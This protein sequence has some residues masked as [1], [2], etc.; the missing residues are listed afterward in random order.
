VPTYVALLRSVN[1]GGRKLPMERLRALFAD[2]GHTNVRTYIQSGNVVFGASARRPATVRSAIEAAIP[3]ELGLDVAVLVRTPAE[4]A[5]VVAANPFG[6]DA[7]VTFLDALPD[8]A[9]VAALD[10]R[11]YAPDGFHVAGR[12]VYV[13]CANGYGRTKI[14]NTFFERKLKTVATTRNWN[15]VTTLH[16]W[17]S[18]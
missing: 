13:H 16:A 4:L 18:G 17:A 12:E 10:P 15:T 3:R 9:S 8:A 14:D 7:Y 5:D 11:A 1:V 6:P 2:L